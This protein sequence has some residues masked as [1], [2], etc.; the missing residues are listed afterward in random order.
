[1]PLLFEPPLKTV[2]SFLLQF[3]HTIIGNIAY[4]PEYLQDL[5]KAFNL[6]QGPN[7]IDKK[8]NQNIHTSDTLY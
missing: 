8:A 4:D 7:P 3:Y 1:M 5:P 2:Q 6:A